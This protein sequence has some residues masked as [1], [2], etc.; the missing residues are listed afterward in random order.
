MS[1]QEK[2]LDR[3]IV[4]TRKAIMEAFDKIC[5]LS[6][7][8]STAGETWKTNANYMVNKR[9]IVDWMTRNDYSWEKEKLSVR[10]SRKRCRQA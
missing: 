3:R 1:D 4:R 10:Y 6:A 5:S 8:N 2:R 7:E 9:F